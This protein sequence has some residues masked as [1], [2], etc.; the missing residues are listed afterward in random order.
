MYM[1]I[2]GKTKGG[3]QPYIRISDFREFMIPIQN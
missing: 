3:S 1:K 2:Y